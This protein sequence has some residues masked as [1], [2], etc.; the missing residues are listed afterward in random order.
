MDGKTV[1]N[2]DQFDG[3]AL[4]RSIVDGTASET[5][6]G[7]FRALVKNLSLALGTH[8]AWVTEYLPRRRRLRALAF[9]LDGRYV[10]HYEYDIRGTPCQHTIDRKTN[11][12]IP[13]RV[14]ALFPDDPDL[15][16]MGAVSYMGFPLLDPE[17]RVLGNLA[18]LDTRRM[19]GSF[20]NLA[21][22]R[23]F[24][25]RATA[26][27][28]RLRAETEIRIR[29][30]RLS[31][32]FAGA[33]DAIVEL[34]P[35]LNVRMLNPSAKD[36]FGIGRNEMAGRPFTSLL[37]PE[38]LG[39]I[40]QIISGLNVRPTG[41][42]RM[43]IPGGLRLLTS[44]GKRIP[45]EATIS[46]IDIGVTP[47]YVL[48]LRDVNERYEAERIIESLR[49]ETRA[50]RQE[51]RA[52][53][54][55]GDLIGKSMP[56]RKTLE[57]AAEV[58][59]TDST[60]LIYG[61][62]GTGK[63]RIAH[64]IH[65]ASGRKNRPLVTVNCAA[66]PQSLMESEFFGHEKGA[67]TG[68]TQRREGRFSLAD[69]GT[70]FLDE[71][72]ELNPEMQAK[73]L[74]VLQEGEFS[75]VG[76]SRTRRVDVRVVAATNRDLSMAVQEGRFRTDL[77]YRLHVFPITV[78]PLRGRGE[79]IA[80]LARHFVDY[81]AA[82]MGRVVPPLEPDAI[83]RL[84]SYEWPGNVRELQNVIE[85]AV[86]TARHGRL[87]LDHALPHAV[88]SI[89]SSPPD[90]QPRRGTIRTVRQMQEM[91]RDNLILAL[92]AARWRVSGKDGAARLLKM[93][94]ST[95]QSRMKALGIKRPDRGPGSPTGSEFSS[96][97]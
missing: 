44:E 71:V 37:D 76:S 87:N 1:S 68:A 17:S 3:D 35:D 42:R 79:D 40:R 94:P 91:E 70:I 6:S 10:D 49:D 2:P 54:L 56:F 97:R 65:S 80:L 53:S 69:G 81:F 52:I 9:W 24:A 33:L 16:E 74:R 45:A 58:A 13:E 77:Y 29:E 84:K 8:G 15:P 11:L 59:P 30:E 90:A 64:A 66:I 72:A 21:L 22:F 73:L 28:L 95:L 57:L 82:R 19:P 27:L 96:L 18:V 88:E 85:R 31:G 39:K 20:R 78:P 43:W 12:H 83:E 25:A 47:H 51:I 41:K 46:R 55:H 86:I 5:G 32:L 7:F 34:D 23:I 4:L 38:D 60:V 92:E 62:T 48:I 50:L 26:E 14:I 36:I 63:E 89:S 75:P 93:P 67:F 61:E